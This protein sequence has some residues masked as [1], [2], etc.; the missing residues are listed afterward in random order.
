MLYVKKCGN[1][2]ELHFI[3]LRANAGWESPLRKECGL[4]LYKTRH[5]STGSRVLKVILN[6]YLAAIIKALKGDEQE[7]VW[8]Q[9]PLSFSK[10]FFFGNLIKKPSYYPF[11]TATLIRRLSHSFFS[12]KD[13]WLWRLL[14]YSSW[15]SKIFLSCST[16]KDLNRRFKP[17]LSKII[18]YWILK[19]F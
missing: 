18:L 2:A 5:L 7:C 6:L 16:L 15:Y 3:W 9:Y 14:T 13:D 17:S 12:I 1:I 19:D 4:F 11:I 10:P 8:K